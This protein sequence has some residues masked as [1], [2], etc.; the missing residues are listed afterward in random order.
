MGGQ[1]GV[2]DRILLDYVG[3]CGAMADFWRGPFLCDVIRDSPPRVPRKVLHASRN[4][5]SVWCRVAL[6]VYFCA[7]SSR[8]RHLPI[9]HYLSTL[10]HRVSPGVGLFIFVRR[11]R[12]FGTSWTMLQS[13]PVMSSQLGPRLFQDGSKMTPIGPM[14]SKDGHKMASRGPRMAPR[15]LKMDPKMTPRGPKM[16][17][18]LFI[19]VRC[20]RGFGTSGGM[21][22]SSPVMFSQLGPRLFQ[23]GSEMTPQGPIRPQDGPKMATKWLQDGLR[24]APKWPQN[25]S[26]MAQRCH[27]N[28]ATMS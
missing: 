11:H 6:V 10:F 14:R 22:Q 3:I 25:N 13:S 12:G 16:G 7:T 23:D 26:K 17:V 8:I 18:G 19:F 20:H 28:G 2:A 15:G 24:M 4:V 9:C 21:V 27:Q 5:C 1:G